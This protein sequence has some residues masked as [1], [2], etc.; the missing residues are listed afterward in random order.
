[1]HVFCFLVPLCVA[2]RQTQ[3]IVHNPAGDRKHFLDHASLYV[4]AYIRIVDEEGV[5]SKEPIV[6]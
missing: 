5:R 1:M 2:R 3:H 6:N 4:C